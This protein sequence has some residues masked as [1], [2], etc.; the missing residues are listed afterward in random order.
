MVTLGYSGL[1]Y[2]SIFAGC[3]HALH[4]Y[5]RVKH[6]FARVGGYLPLR[7]QPLAIVSHRPK[8]S[9][10]AP[11]GRCG[12]HPAWNGCACGL[13]QNLLHHWCGRALGLTRGIHVNRKQTLQHETQ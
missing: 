7:R 1:R 10:L 2:A 3:F 8:P 13:R 12:V 5:T 9:R 4:R 11:M 6:F